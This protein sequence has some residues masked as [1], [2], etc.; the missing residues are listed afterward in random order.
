MSH[1]HDPGGMPDRIATKADLDGLTKTLTAAFQSDPLWGRWAF[2]DA[3]DL[4]VWLRFYLASALR[5]PCVRVIGDYAAAAVWI[6][7]GGSELTAEDEERIEPL[8]DRLVGPRAADVLELLTRFEASHPREPP[9]YYL[10]LLGTHPD[11]RGRGLGLA[12]L[13]DSLASIDTEGVPAYL[14]S[15]NPI[16]NRRYE[17][18]GFR[19]VGEFTTPDGTRTVT[20]MWRDAEGPAGSSEA[21]MSEKG[22]SVIERAYAAWSAD[23]LD[24]FFEHWAVNA[25]W[26]SIP[27][28][29]DDRGPMHG[30]HAVHAYLD[31]WLETFDDFRVELVE[32]T[33]VG[34][35][36]VV[37]VLRY[38]GRAKRS[39]M[40]IPSSSEAAVF[41]VR[42]GQIVGGGEY[43]TRADALKATE[44]SE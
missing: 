22:S 28:A 18:V 21:A 39:G 13:S 4:A 30:R 9:H 25:D 41:V 15:T 23:G 26:R 10:S 44:L 20:T 11:Y 3:G 16:N 27:G 19:Q 35:D 43:A 12:L 2:P 38:G 29:A 31:D 7:P 34:E 37:A 5:Y 40:E 42:R 36:R 24:A 33:D 8:V 14:E 17:H 6:P 32:V 1:E